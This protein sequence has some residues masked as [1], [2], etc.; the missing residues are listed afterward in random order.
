MTN[1][2]QEAI[3]YLKYASAKRDVKDKKD[4]SYSFTF[5]DDEKE[6]LKNYSKENKGLVFLYLLCKTEDL[7]DSEVIVLKYEE[8]QNVEENKAITI[9]L[10]KNKK[11]AILFR[12]G[13]KAKKDAYPIPRNRIEKKFD[14]LSEEFMKG[15]KHHNKSK[16]IYEYSVNC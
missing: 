8:Y 11:N 4:F 12:R 5:S 9:R 13:S 1:T 7:K 2:S 14:E 10:E 15:F 3:L 16:E 6:E